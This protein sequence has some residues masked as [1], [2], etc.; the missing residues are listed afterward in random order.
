MIWHLE[1]SL[2]VWSLV[3][4]TENVNRS[5]WKRITEKVNTKENLKKNP[6]QFFPIPILFYVL[7]FVSYFLGNH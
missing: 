2:V 7:L 4:D 6:K 1:K 5:E 3:A